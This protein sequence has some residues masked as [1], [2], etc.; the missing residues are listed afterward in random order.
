MAYAHSEPLPHERA[1]PIFEPLRRVLLLVPPLALAAL[2]IFHPQPDE[3]AQ[4]MME[5]A[6]WFALFHFIQLGLVGLVALSVLLLADSFG[7]ATA[8]STRIGIG[9]FLVFF[10]AYDTIAG[11]GTGLAMRSAR[12]LS[13]V[14]QQGVFEVVKDWPALGTPFVLSIFG[15]LGWVI[16]VGSLAFAARRLGAPRLEWVFILLAGVFLLAGHPAPQG[17][18]A[19]GSLF[20][21]ALFHERRRSNA[22]PTSTQDDV[23]AAA[24][25]RSGEA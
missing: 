2:E 25:L 13:P 7:Q 4:A 8:W 14:Q 12:D 23:G 3:S 24:L 19:F 1:W 20:L 17:T 6:T 9:V 5:V 16:A 10:S 22:R 18:L 15:T 11:I 21:A